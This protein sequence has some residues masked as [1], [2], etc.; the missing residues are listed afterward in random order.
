MGIIN[1][2]EKCLDSPYL[3]RD[4]T[5]S[6]LVKELLS[7]A[8]ER[9]EAASKLRDAPKSE[10]TNIG[11]LC[12]EAMFCC[13]RALVYS[14]GYRE[15]GLSCLLLAADRLFVQQQTLDPNHLV[16]FQRAQAMKLNTEEALTASST[17]LQRTQELVVSTQEVV[18]SEDR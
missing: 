1:T 17:F 16:Q 10:A 9:I 18:D 7:K 11:L 5:A 15:A 13:L 14:Q 3:S 12:Y 6:A 2:F 4:E 8:A